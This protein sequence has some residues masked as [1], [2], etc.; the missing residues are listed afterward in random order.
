MGIQN[1][2]P[3]GKMMGRREYREGQ[4]VEG[5]ENRRESKLC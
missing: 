5:E 1:R 2:L 3:G 4:G